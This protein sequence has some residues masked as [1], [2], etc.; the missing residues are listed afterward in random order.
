M[1]VVRCTLEYVY[2]GQVLNNVLYFNDLSGIKTD[3]Q[4]ASELTNN[5]LQYIRPMQAS[6]MAYTNWY[7]AGTGA[8]GGGAN[9]LPVI[10][11]TS[12]GLVMTSAFSPM[13]ILW[14]LR[15]AV[16]GRSFR[17]RVYWGAI[18]NQRTTTG[19][20]WISS[21]LTTMQTA[22]V[23]L[24]GRY[25]GA[26]PASGIQWGVWSKKLQSFHAIET[27]LIRDIPAVQRRRNI[28]VGD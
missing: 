14:S 28:N 7:V 24:L 11:S 5:F 25:G 16:N 19:G 1:G 18:D 26:N 10:P 12:G 17:G 27:I 13:A 3:Q 6:T 15:T 23:N 21:Y 22:T 9:K 20:R 2:L 4:I 8:P